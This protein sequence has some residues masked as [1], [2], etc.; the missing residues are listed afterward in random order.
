MLKSYNY[1]TLP[2]GL[3][4]FKAPLKNH[5]FSRVRSSFIVGLR[6]Q[7]IFPLTLLGRGGAESART[8]FRWQFLHEKRGLEVPNFL[9]FLIHYELSVS[10]KRNFFWFFTVFWSELER[11]G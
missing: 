5:D 7:K 11:T 2:Y 6:S 8:F 4:A 1:L 10:E 9:L 3:G